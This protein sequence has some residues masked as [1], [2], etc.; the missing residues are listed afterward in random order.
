[1]LES[2]AF[3]GWYRRETPGPT[4]TRATFRDVSATRTF[5]LSSMFVV[6]AVVAGCGK[7]SGPAAG[8]EPEG[9]P[10]DPVRVCKQEGQNCVYSEGKLGL[11]TMKMGCD[12]GS[13]FT[14]MSL[15]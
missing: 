10:S 4:D 6:C 2:L 14:C 13:C 11:C 3:R 8:A 7:S 1:M 12:A 5:L 9:T 15:H